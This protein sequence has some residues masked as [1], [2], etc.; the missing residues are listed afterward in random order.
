MESTTKSER[1]NITKAGKDIHLIPKD[2]IYSN[3][4]I[5]LHGFGSEPGEYVPIFDGSGEIDIIPPKTK[6]ILLSAP[7]MP[8]TKMGGRTISSWYNLIQGDEIDFN[9]IIKNSQ[10]VM[11]IIKNEGKRI[12]YDK[13]IVGG[14]SQGACMSYYI[15]YNLPFILGGIIV[16]SGK[17]FEDVEIL[18]DNE[19]LK[20][21]IGHGDQD[22]VISYSKMEKSI[23]RISNKDNL[24]LHVYKNTS[25][26]ITHDEFNDIGKFMEKIFN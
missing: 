6:I 26:Q 2:G 13:I 3:L 1:F 7:I 8:I 14:F 21:F 20:V 10:K 12:G 19:K 23:E 9:D 17:L 15:G 25:H 18:K 5:W 24:D 22:N 4:L 11:K 16:C